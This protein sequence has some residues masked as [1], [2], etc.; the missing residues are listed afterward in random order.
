MTPDPEVGA[1]R[2]HLPLLLAVEEVVVVLHGDELRPAVLCR[3]VLRLAELPGPHRRRTEIAHLPCTDDVVERLHRLLDRC[4]R[5]PAMDLI[6]VDV[7]G[8]EPRQALVDLAEDRLAG[9][10]GTVGSFVHAPMHLGGQ[11]DLVPIGE[12][13]KRPAHDLLARSRRIDVR[14]IEEVHAEFDG[15]PD[16]RTCLV[17]LP[18]STGGCHERD[19][20]SSCTPGRPATPRA[21]TVPASRTPWRQACQATRR[22][23]R[24]TPPRGYA[25]RAAGHSR[26]RGAP[27]RSTAGSR[28]RR[29]GAAAGHPDRP[30]EAGRRSHAA[31]RCRRWR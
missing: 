14:G 17:L 22:A 13:A 12:V 18:G 6:E 10:S 23:V 28:G 1:Q 5:V 4:H 27:C 3:H 19:R 9:Q 21:R 25:S 7:V 8:A 30:R 29:Q 11:H 16:E 15:R 31:S 26:A 20:R 24:A 2:Q